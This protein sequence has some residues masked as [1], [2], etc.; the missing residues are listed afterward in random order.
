MSTRQNSQP[1]TTIDDFIGARI[2]ER[3]LTLGLTQRQLGEMIDVARDVISKFEQGDT[4]LSAG[5]LYE[6]ARALDAPTTYF[7]D[8]FDGD[9]APQPDRRRVLK[10]MHLLGEIQDEKDLA[11]LSQLTR[12]LAGR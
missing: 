8:G 1:S 3:R 12:A 10:L 9:K 7:Y 4:R 11:T 6:I 5:R 2:R